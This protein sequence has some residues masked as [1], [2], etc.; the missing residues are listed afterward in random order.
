MLWSMIAETLPSWKTYQSPQSGMQ[1]LIIVLPDS[2]IGLNFFKFD[3]WFEEYLVSTHKVKV[4]CKFH[5]IYLTILRH[6]AQD[7]CAT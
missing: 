1:W 3:R 7:V 6:I 4:F 5:Y 2:F